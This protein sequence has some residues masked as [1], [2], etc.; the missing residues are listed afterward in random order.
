MHTKTDSRELFVLSGPN[1]AIRGTYHRPRASNSASQ[2]EPNRGRIGIVFLNS[3]S[4]T[5]AGNGDG[6]VYL[7]DSFAGLGFPTFRIDL[8]G[9]GDA[10]GNPPENLHDFINRGG[11]ASAAASAIRELA[12]RFGLS[13]VIL[14]GHCAGAVS[15]IY[16]AAMSGDCRG[17]ILRAPYFHLPP[18]PR[19]KIRQNLSIWALKSR[20]GDR[21]SR[22][23]D[24]LKAIRLRLR[25][26]RVP[27]NANRPLL[28][29]WKKVAS[30]GVPALIVIGPAR[31]STGTQPRLGQFDFLDYAVHLGGPQAKVEVRVAENTDHSFA[32]LLGRNEV[33]QIAAEWLEAV[34][35][36]SPIR[37]LTSTD[38][39]AEHTADSRTLEINI[40]EKGWI[41]QT[42]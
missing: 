38:V 23:F 15:A 10:A 37:E 28:Q 3:L 30:S 29:G 8:P 36:R 35:P 40:S 2:N 24:K 6:A 18:P 27:E 14:E 33:R 32:N 19:P 39:S 41:K 16:T 25:G 42:Q 1:S 22:V 26:R 11:Y 20:T 17:L 7:A 12:G 9:F 34:F 5:R 4:A 31:R 13:G 21:L